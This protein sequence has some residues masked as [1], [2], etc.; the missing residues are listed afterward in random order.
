MIDTKIANLEKE[1]RSARQDDSLPLLQSL[2]AKGYDKAIWHIH[3]LLHKEKD[4]CD[5]YNGKVFDL[6]ALTSNLRYSAPIFE[7]AHVNCFSKDAE[8]YTDKG[9]KLFSELDKTEQVATLNKETQELEWQKPTNY[10]KY[11]FDG[12]LIE[13]KNQRFYSYVTPN[14]RFAVKSRETGKIT[15]REVQDLTNND[16]RLKDGFDIPLG[17]EYNNEN[18]DN[19][20]I[21]TLEFTQSEYAKLM[22]WYLSEGCCSYQGK[23][24]IIN[25]AQ[26]KKSG[27]EKIKR[28]LEEPLKRNGIKLT[29]FTKV[30]VF[31]NKELYMYLRKFGKCYEKYLPY[32]LKNLNKNALNNFLEAYIAGD[33]RTQESCHLKGQ[34]KK[35]IKKEIYTTS[36]QLADDLCEVILKSGHTV[37]YGLAHKAGT[38]GG[39][40]NGITLK[41]NYDCYRITVKN[42]Q[43]SRGYYLKWNYKEYHDIVY[44]VSVPNEIILVRQNGKVYWSGNCYCYLLCYSTTNPD[45]EMVVCDWTGIGEEGRIVDR[46]D[47]STLKEDF[48]KLFGEYQKALETVETNKFITGE[49]SDPDSGLYSFDIT[50]YDD[51]YFNVNEVN[52]VRD[53]VLEVVLD[54]ADRYGIKVEDANIAGN[55]L[56][57]QTN[58]LL[59]YYRFSKS[60][61]M[62][63]EWNYEPRRQELVNVM[64]NLQNLQDWLKSTQDNLNKLLMEIE[65]TNANQ[66]VEKYG[67]KETTKVE[68]YHKGEYGDKG[69]NIQITTS[70]K[71]VYDKAKVLFFDI[72]QVYE[73]LNWFL[74]GD[75]QSGEGYWLMF[76]SHSD[77]QARFDEAYNWL[78]SQLEG[79]E[80]TAGRIEYLRDWFME[81]MMNFYLKTSSFAPNSSPEEKKSIIEDYFTKTNE[82]NYI[83]AFFSGIIEADPTKNKQYVQWIAKQFFNKLRDEAKTVSNIETVMRIFDEDLYKYT[84]DIELYEKL[85]LHKKLP[86]EHEVERSTYGVGERGLGRF[87]RE[88]RIDK[89][90]PRDVNQ[91]QS[92]DELYRFLKQYR[93]NPEYYYSE[94]EKKA[95][96][97]GG[98]LIHDGAQWQVWVPNT[99]EASCALGK[100]SRWCTTSGGEEGMFGRYTRS[101]TLFIIINKANPSDKYQFHFEDGQFMDVDDNSVNPSDILNEEPEMK[102]RIYD[103]LKSSGSGRA[104]DFQTIILL[105]GTEGIHELYKGYETQPKVINRLIAQHDLAFDEKGQSYFT[106]KDWDSDEILDLFADDT[107]QDY[108]ELAKS[109]FTGDTQDWFL[110]DMKYYDV[111]NYSSEI[112]GMNKDNWAKI[113]LYLKSEGVKI[114]KGLS[115]ENLLEFLNE[116]EEE[117]WADELKDHLLRAS[118]QA[119]EGAD[120]GATYTKF[121]QA[122]EKAIGAKGEYKQFAGKDWLSF[123]VDLYEWVGGVDGDSEPLE[124]L[125]S[126]IFNKLRDDGELIKIYEVDRGIYGDVTADDLNYS[127]DY[128]LDDLVPKPVKKPIKRVKKQV[129]DAMRELVGKVNYL[130]G[131]PLRL[132]VLARL[133]KTEGF[134]ITGE[135]IFNPSK[136]RIPDVLK[137]AI[138]DAVE[139]LN[140]NRNYTF[141]KHFMDSLRNRAGGF[142]ENILNFVKTHTYTTGEI[143][144]V[145]LDDSYY[146]RKL[147]FKVEVPAEV[148]GVKDIIRLVVTT[149]G[150]FITFFNE[151]FTGKKITNPAVRYD[152]YAVTKK[153]AGKDGIASQK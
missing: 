88:T 108:R 70:D 106:V 17:I 101:G 15:L 47:R 120:E 1:A 83:N 92:G 21:G 100:N 150:N 44:C 122:V 149:E 115:P 93:N 52:E 82:G 20:K 69:N 141:T 116:N 139:E 124:D 118:V 121:K 151:S 131:K 76:E 114:P 50:M 26:L 91:F 123:S 2:I 127:L 45:L 107:R 113:K 144:E 39:T 130:Q 96:A 75:V 73:D 134:D 5:L 59:E 95:I 105:K 86:D 85:K 40:L 103:R 140:T 10:I 89:I 31:S 36:K 74:Q 79:I 129:K 66:Q 25:I 53:K 55:Y 137:R 33:G 16:G 46:Q 14:H 112:E 153:S 80:K 37:S 32:E 6:K 94:G 146:L 136:Q 11:K 143:E 78:Y 142:E 97:E 84:D 72:K 64:L 7:H 54:T 42:C 43:Y 138:V 128:V 4:I 99:Y 125:G 48:Y 56:L 145:S 3:E 13:L 22:G 71:E 132:S 109:L 51:T 104:D 119:Q 18:N 28:D 117:G 34:K 62:D 133:S 67:M 65:S 19:I 90:N 29:Y 111:D 110:Y 81:N 126:M 58:D 135:K 49:Y 23:G 9:W 41:R 148:A 98:K 57:V 60:D 77:N 68:S 12:D 63:V 152:E 61:F 102:P 8:I 38:A 35:S 87:Q 27:I 30:F 24:Y 147:L